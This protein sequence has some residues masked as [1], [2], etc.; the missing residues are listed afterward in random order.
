[1][2]YVNQ[3][4]KNVHTQLTS[5]RIADQISE[6]SAFDIHGFFTIGQD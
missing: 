6:I 2:L 3:L 1:M 4:N 5:G